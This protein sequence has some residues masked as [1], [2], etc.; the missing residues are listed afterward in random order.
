G[1]GDSGGDGNGGGSQENIGRR[2]GGFGE[3]GGG[4]RIIVQGGLPAFGLGNAAAH[5]PDSGSA[6]EA[7]A[8]FDGGTFASGSGTG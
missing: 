7:D 4:N 6:S 8:G 3:P 5:L 1:G 2:P